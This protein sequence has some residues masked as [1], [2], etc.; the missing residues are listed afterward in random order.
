MIAIDEEMR[1]RKRLVSILRQNSDYVQLYYDTYG[2]TPVEPL[3]AYLHTLKGCAWVNRNDLRQ[4]VENDPGRLIEWD[5]GALIRATYGF[6]P[7]KTKSRLTEIAPPEVL[8]YGTHRKLLRQ[9][10]AGGLLPIASEFVQ[11]AEQPEDI[12]MPEDTLSLV[13]VRAR[14][15]H[16]AGI[17]FYYDNERY[18]FS[19]SIA[20]SFLQ[21]YVH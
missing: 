10:L 9:V 8:Y 13:T 14:E 12:G 3:L 4:V 21:P 20:P 7:T 15:A 16:E 5:G 2:Y 6:M 11:L 1:L 17:R 18:S 19:E